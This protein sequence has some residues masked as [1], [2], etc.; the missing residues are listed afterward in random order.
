MHTAA[1]PLSTANLL[2]EIGPPMFGYKSLYSFRLLV[3][4]LRF[5]LYALNTQETNNTLIFPINN[6][7]A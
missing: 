4:F 5:Y 6:V 1:K 7:S 2:T 3:L